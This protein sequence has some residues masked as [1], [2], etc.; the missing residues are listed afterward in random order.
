MWLLLA[1]TARAEAPETPTGMAGH[2]QDAALM[3]LAV[4]VDDKKAARAHTKSLATSDVAPAPLREAAQDLLGSLGK[5]ERA[6]PAVADL[7]GA[8]AKCHLA[9]GRGP[10]PTE[11][12][13][14]PGA[15]AVDRHVMASMFVWIGLVTPLE[16]PYALGL[17][18]LVRDLDT[19]S[20]DAVRA[21]AETFHTLV[22]NAKAARSWAERRDK[23]GT[24]LPACVE[25]HELAGATFR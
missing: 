11:V 25:C 20:N 13:E 9:G 12:S 19:N 22:L 8:C 4:A 7:V 5:A 1:L 24:M 6:G 16:Q 10:E 17:D 15:S 2:F 14:V 21:S 3:M 23:F 18:A